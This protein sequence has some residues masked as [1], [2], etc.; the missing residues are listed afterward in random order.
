MNLVQ[1]LQISTSK[2][3]REAWARDR[4]SA[5]P[6]EADPSHGPQCWATPPRLPRWV[7]RQVA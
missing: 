1:D 7:G 4:P 2:P 6:A 3:D 5:V